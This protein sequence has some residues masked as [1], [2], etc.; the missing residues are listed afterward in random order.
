MKFL[1]EIYLSYYNHLER[2]S[3]ADDLT[4]NESCQ[5]DYNRLKNAGATNEF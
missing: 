4:T 5:S 2:S 3:K 1:L